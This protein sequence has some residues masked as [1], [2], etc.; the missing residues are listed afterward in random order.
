MRT[1]PW[2]TREAE[3]IFTSREDSIEERTPVVTRSDRPCLSI[4]AVS[5]STSFIFSSVVAGWSSA[6]A[7]SAASAAGTSSSA[8]FFD[9]P[10]FFL[11]SPSAARFARRAALDADTIL[12]MDV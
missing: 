1:L 7:P 11:V 4:C 8:P 10:S 9:L 6:G 5:F 3:V 12:S 2:N